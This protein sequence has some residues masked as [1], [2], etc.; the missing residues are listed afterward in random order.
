METDPSSAT[1]MSI[2]RS[3]KK[4]MEWTKEKM[5]EL[6]LRMGWSQSD[7]ARHLEVDSQT[8]NQIE[9]GLSID[10]DNLRSKLTF[11]W[12]QAESIS[13]EV[14]MSALAEKTL[15]AHNLNQLFQSELN[16]K[17]IE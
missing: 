11:Y 16:D 7:L 13:D 10:I 1:F 15:E 2:K 3:K 5:R 8:I 4:F 14:Q 6:R 17:Y 12:R 9:R